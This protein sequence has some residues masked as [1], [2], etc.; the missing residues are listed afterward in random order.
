MCIQEGRSRAD[1]PPEEGR[2]ARPRGGSGVVE[3]AIDVHDLVKTYPGG[4]RALT[5]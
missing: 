5:A 1:L 2:L 4:V 3:P